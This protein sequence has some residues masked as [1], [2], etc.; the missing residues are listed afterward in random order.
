[1]RRRRW[2][3][4][5]SSLGMLAMAVGTSSPLAI[6]AETVFAI[7]D[8]ESIADANGSSRIL[9]SFGDTSMLDG[10]LVTSAVLEVALPGDSPS[11]DLVLTLRAVETAW[12]DRTPTW[13][14]P[15]RTPG[16]D[17]SDI[18]SHAV[19]LDKDRPARRLTFDVTE[20]VREIADGDAPS[21]GFLLGV[22]EHRG[23]GLD[24][25]EVAVLGSLADATLRV[26]HRNIAALGLSSSRD[27]IRN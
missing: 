25:G 17:L 4:H 1:M 23:A 14:S 21:C 27:I 5:F 8:I 7:R 22:P 3:S 6:A 15:W 10:Q 9:M 26:T 13:T 2:L 24:S 11:D 16:G 18:A 20:M 19:V 12:A